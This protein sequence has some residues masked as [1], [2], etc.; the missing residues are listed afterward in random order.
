MYS[1]LGIFLL[2]LYSQKW[3]SSLLL[4]PIFMGTREES[5]VPG[6]FIAPGGKV[7]LAR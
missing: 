5:E 7:G 2:L 6:H 4:L 3:K 1:L